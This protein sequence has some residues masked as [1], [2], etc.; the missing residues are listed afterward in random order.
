ME[1]KLINS[2]QMP[3]PLKKRL[4][5][6]VLH[7]KLHPNK[8]CDERNSLATNKKQLL[9]GHKQRS[10]EHASYKFCPRHTVASMLFIV[11][12]INIKHQ[13]SFERL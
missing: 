6:Q 1:L 2:V 10:T 8:K 5:L 7:T 9:R 13:R 3:I 11:L 4:T 12:Q